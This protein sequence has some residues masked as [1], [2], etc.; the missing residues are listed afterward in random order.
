[1]IHYVFKKRTV[2]FDQLQER[3]GA[4]V[5]HR[6]L[7]HLHRLYRVRIRLTKSGNREIS[8]AISGS[9]RTLP[10]EVRKSDARVVAV[11]LNLRVNVDERRSDTI[12]V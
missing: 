9:S 10:L 1:M 5:I 11:R 2:L 4:S 12:V 6:D 3:G 7:R 8:R